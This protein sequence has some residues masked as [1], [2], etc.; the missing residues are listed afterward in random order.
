MCSGF[1]CS[2]APVRVLLSNSPKDTLELLGL[3]GVEDNVLISP[4]LQRYPDL[5]TAVIDGIRANYYDKNLL[6]ILN[7]AKKDPSTEKSATQ[8]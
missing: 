8:L 2:G 6:P 1:F 3:D 7:A 5:K 4:L